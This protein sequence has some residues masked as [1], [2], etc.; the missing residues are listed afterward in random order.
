MKQRLRQ[1]FSFILKP[2]ESG[3]VGP[4]YKDSHRTVL[5]VVGVLFL[6]LATVSATA[7]VYTGKLG[8]LIPV[9]VFFGIGGVSLIVGTLGSDAAVSKM[10]GNR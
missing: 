5:N 10:W 3:Q 8:A 1:L 6:A 9:L 4:S 2:L 7:L